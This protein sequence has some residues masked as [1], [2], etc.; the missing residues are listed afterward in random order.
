MHKQAIASKLLE[1]NIDLNTISHIEILG[2]D[3]AA[4]SG[5]VHYYAG[6]GTVFF[7]QI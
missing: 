1:M 5:V 4:V 6:R 3:N 7:V 2:A